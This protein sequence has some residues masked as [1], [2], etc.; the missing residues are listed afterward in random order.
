MN[1]NFE[2]RADK[3]YMALLRINTKCYYG[4]NDTVFTLH[5][6]SRWIPLTF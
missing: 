1:Q 4:I 3:V 6:W 2:Y 5:K